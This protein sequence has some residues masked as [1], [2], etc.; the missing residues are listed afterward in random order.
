M[1][2]PA[3]V[4]GAATGQPAAAAGR[5]S[6]GD[7]LEWAARRRRRRHGAG[8]NCIKIGLSGKSILR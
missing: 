8:G 4:V 2:L 1:F 7:P 5:V 3:A 6:R